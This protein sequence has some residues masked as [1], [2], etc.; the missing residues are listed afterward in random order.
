M[1][2]GRVFQVGRSFVSSL[3]SLKAPVDTKPSWAEHISKDNFQIT[4]YC[5]KLKS[6]HETVDKLKKEVEN[7]A[8]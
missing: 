6:L 8:R 7:R 4:E 5:L 3:V 1:I 2:A